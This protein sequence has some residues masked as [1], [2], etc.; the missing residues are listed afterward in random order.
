MQIPNQILWA[1]ACSHIHLY[2]NYTNTADVQTTLFA[3]L[4]QAA[5]CL[6]RGGRYLKLKTRRSLSTGEANKRLNIKG[7]CKEV[8]LVIYLS[9]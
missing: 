3:L 4:L 8:L 6:G 9:S 1:M 2:A 5:I 7:M